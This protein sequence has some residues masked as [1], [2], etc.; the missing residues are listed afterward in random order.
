VAPL[1]AAL[2]ARLQGGWRDGEVG[3]PVGDPRGHVRGRPPQFARPQH[4]QVL[5]GEV[6]AEY[7]GDGDRLSGKVSRLGNRLNQVPMQPGMCN[8]EIS[9][10][11]IQPASCISLTSSPTDTT[12]TNSCI[13]PVIATRPPLARALPRRRAD[14]RSSSRRGTL[15]I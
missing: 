7:Q 6:R 14:V 1:P 5:R 3:G 8:H 2:G 9:V 4:P 11:P 10:V 15:G 13:T 12:S